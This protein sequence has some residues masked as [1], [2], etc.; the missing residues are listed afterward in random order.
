MDEITIKNILKAQSFGER[1]ATDYLTEYMNMSEIMHH[2]LNEK[3]DMVYLKY[4][5]SDEKYGNILIMNLSNV[6]ISFQTIC[7]ITI[8]KKETA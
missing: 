8:L 6:F 1:S 4:Y 3:P 5:D 7:L 2:H